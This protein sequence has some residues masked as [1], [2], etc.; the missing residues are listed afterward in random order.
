MLLITID[1]KGKEMNILCKLSHAHKNQSLQ[2]SST[3][4]SSTTCSYIFSVLRKH[5][6]CRPPSTS[7][8]RAIQSVR[9]ADI[10][11]ATV[12][13]IGMVVAVGILISMLLTI[14][15]VMKAGAV[16]RTAADHA[17]IAAAQQYTF[18]SA[19]PCATANTVSQAN[20]AELVSCMIQGQDTLVSVQV[21]T[22]MP[23]IAYAHAY[24][25]AG[26]VQCE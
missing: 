11:S 22:H 3:T 16:A 15:L 12:V 14:A 25:R 19:D 9:K 8:T 2:M 20:H 4:T 13:G 24:A 1:T 5:V 21:A 23:L 6:R 18:G 26:P 10:G 17:A 7:S